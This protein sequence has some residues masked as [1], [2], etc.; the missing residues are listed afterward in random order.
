[1]NE[2]AANLRSKRPLRNRAIGAALA[3]AAA[4]LAGCATPVAVTA[5]ISVA[6]AGTAAFISGQLVSARQATL[7][8]AWEATLGAMDELAFDRRAVRPPDA[9]ESQGRSAYIMGQDDGG[10]Q[11]KVKLERAS[12]AVTQIKIRINLLGDQALARLVLSRI[13]ARLPLPPPPE[14]VR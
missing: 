3:L 2:P 12:D 7:E 13:D 11:V 4:L 6:Q 5:G 8:Q 9:H 10:P 1:V 14:V